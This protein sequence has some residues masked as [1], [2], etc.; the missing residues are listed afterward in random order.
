[1]KKKIIVAAVLAGVIGSQTQAAAPHTGFS[2]G[3]NLGYTSVDGKLK[4]DFPTTIPASSD[5]SNFGASSPVVGLFL[6][7]GWAPNPHGFYLGGELFGQYENVKAKRED[8]I[9]LAFPSFTTKINTN[10]SFGAAAKI[11]FICKDAL[12]FGKIGAIS[13]KWK[14]EFTNP[15]VPETVSK[16]QRKTGLLLGIGGDYALARNWT[17]GGEFLY[18]IYGSLKLLPTEFSFSHKPKVSTFNLRLKYAF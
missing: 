17:L 11:G 16:N 2:V 14:F 10:N 5:N 9:G 15:G 7:Y 13:T 8:L 4:R 1:M 3:A 18:A 12:F 6:G